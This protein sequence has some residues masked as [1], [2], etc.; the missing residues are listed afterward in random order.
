MRLTHTYKSRGMSPL[1]RALAEF[2]VG[3]VMGIT[4]A[5]MVVWGLLA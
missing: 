2:A 4:L 5:V 1:A 3:G